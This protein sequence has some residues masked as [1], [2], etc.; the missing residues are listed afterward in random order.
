MRLGS[1]S[2]KY[3][4]SGN[5]ATVAQTEGDAGG[6]SYGIYQFASGPGV[7]QKFVE[8]LQQQP[9]PYTEYGNQLAAAG[10]P[11]CDQSF[12]DKWAEI[13]TADEEGFGDLQDQYTQSIYFDS[14]ADN[15]MG[16]Y[17]FDISPR[18]VALKQ[19]L[20]SNCVQ[21]GSYYGAEVFRDAADL[22]GQNLEDMSDHDI[23]YNIYEL[24]LTDMSW[25]SGSPNL[26]PGLFRRWNDE[27]DDALAML[28]SE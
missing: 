8:W 7:V 10:N 19:V 1:L 20:F 18:S 5:A 27:R 9:E 3:E 12:A 2:A 15:L 23:I 28:A 6:W 13:G 14:G 21:H 22:A 17:G 25:S 26:R 24:K 11:T 16:N 4:S